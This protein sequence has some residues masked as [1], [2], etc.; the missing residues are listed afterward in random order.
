MNAAAYTPESQPQQQADRLQRESFHSGPGT[1]HSSAQHPTLKQV[2]LRAYR[3]VDAQLLQGT[4]V[5]VSDVIKA[6]FA[7]LS[8]RCLSEIWNQARTNGRSEKAAA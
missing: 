4:G 8:R 1:P 3:L 6:D 7:A 5:L 2:L